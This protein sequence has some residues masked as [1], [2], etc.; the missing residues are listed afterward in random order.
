MHREFHLAI[1]HASGNEY[2]TTVVAPLRNKTELVFS[3]LADSRGIM[4]GASIRASATPSSAATPSSP[5][6]APSSTWLR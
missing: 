3:M 5:G 4:A 2:L 1:E 6:S